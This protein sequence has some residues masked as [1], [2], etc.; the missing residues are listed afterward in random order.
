MFLTYF[1][2]L[3]ST[4]CTVPVINFEIIIAVTLLLNCCS[5]RT[6]KFTDVPIIIRKICKVLQTRSLT[7]SYVLRIQSKSFFMK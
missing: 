4:V 3:C 1:V 5:V 2:L 7:N 6:H